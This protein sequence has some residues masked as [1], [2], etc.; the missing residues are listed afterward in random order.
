MHLA[1]VL[2]WRHYQ[3]T[4]QLKSSS[5][6]FTKCPCAKHRTVLCRINQEGKGEMIVF[7]EFLSSWR[8]NAQ[9]PLFLAGYL[10]L[11]FG[12]HIHKM[13]IIPIYH[14]TVVMIK[15]L[16][17]LRKKFHGEYADSRQDM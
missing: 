5:K 15:K 14:S 6:P 13:G 3:S 16:E 4:L 7:Q 12:A 1:A 17:K 2:L 11:D 8:D 9:E 10:N